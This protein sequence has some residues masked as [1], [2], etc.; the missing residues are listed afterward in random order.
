LDRHLYR[1]S[2]LHGDPH[3]Q[4]VRAGQC[5][6]D[7]QWRSVPITTNELRFMLTNPPGATIAGVIRRQNVKW[8]GVGGVGDFFGDFQMELSGPVLPP[9]PLAGG[10]ERIGKLSSDGNGN[11][12]ANT[13]A[14]YNGMIVPEALSGAY[15]VDQNCALI[16]KYTLQTAAGPLK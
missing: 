7:P 13:N 3:R 9:S 11:F 14:S 8:C 15:I 12:T 6:S 10:F 16:L 1:E 5:P 2:E 4:P